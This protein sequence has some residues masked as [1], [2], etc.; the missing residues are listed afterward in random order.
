MPTGLQLGLILHPRGYLTTL[1]TFL[2]VTSC[3][4]GSITIGME[5]LLSIQQCTA[6]T[7]LQLVNDTAPKV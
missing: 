4:R 2:V 3:L 5:G 7:N 6:V 1:E